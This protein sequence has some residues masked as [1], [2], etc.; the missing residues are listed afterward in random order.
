VEVQ[1]VW[2]EWLRSKCG[3]EEDLMFCGECYVFM[4]VRNGEE[5]VWDE[6]DL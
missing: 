6:T 5:V 4:R 2:S 1:K 3:V